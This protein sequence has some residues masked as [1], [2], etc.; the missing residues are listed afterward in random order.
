MTSSVKVPVE[1]TLLIWGRE[2][3][4]YSIEEAAGKIGI[5]PENLAAAE[6]NEA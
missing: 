4:G 6:A 1:P 3:A 2:T 5:K